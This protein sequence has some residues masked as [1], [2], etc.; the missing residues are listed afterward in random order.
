MFTLRAK[1]AAG[2]ELIAGQLKTHTMVHVAFSAPTGKLAGAGTMGYKL[3]PAQ[4]FGDCRISDLDKYFPPLW[5]D[6][7]RLWRLAA[8]R[9]A[10]D[11]KSGTRVTLRSGPPRGAVCLPRLHHDEH[12]P[13]NY[14]EAPTSAIANPPP[15]R[16]RAPTCASAWTTHYRSTRMRMVPQD[17][18]TEACDSSSSA[19]VGRGG[20]SRAR[21]QAGIAAVCHYRG[22]TAVVKYV[23][24]SI[25]LRCVEQPAPGDY[26]ARY[27]RT[28][29]APASLPRATTWRDVYY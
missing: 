20:C 13:I 4:L 2:G 22:G 11:S 18:G 17:E 5:T 14:N 3:W 9:D 12:S 25:G 7:R 16:A 8:R 19:G 1:D 29:G 24:W 15:R 10:A 21:K 27:P 28:L 23:R 26:I 6:R